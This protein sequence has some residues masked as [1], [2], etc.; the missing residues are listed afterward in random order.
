MRE[1]LLVSLPVGDVARMGNGG[2]FFFVS[3]RISAFAAE[4]RYFER[5]RRTARRPSPPGGA[6]DI[7]M[8]GSEPDRYNAREI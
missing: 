7:E 8:S 1:R 2:A 4:R 6:M 5:T 3:T